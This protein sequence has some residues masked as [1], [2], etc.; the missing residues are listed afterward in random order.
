MNNKYRFVSKILFSVLALVLAVSLPA[1]SAATETLQRRFLRISYELKTPSGKIYASAANEG[2]LVSFDG[3]SLWY[4]RSSGLPEK[5]VYPFKASE[6]ETLTSISYD[7]SNENRLVCTTAFGLFVSENAGMNWKEI[8]LGGPIRRA[9]YITGAALSPFNNG[10]I[11]V[12]TSFSGLYETTDYGKTWKEVAEKS[13]IYRGAGFKE[14]IA[15]A[16]YSQAEEGVIYLAYSFGNGLYISSADRSRW[17]RIQGL[18]DE[19]S[20]RTIQG[21]RNRLEVIFTS[22]TAVYD[23]QSGRWSEFRGSSPAEPGPGRSARLDA[24]GDHR[25]M[26]I[27]PWHASGQRLLDHFDFMEKNGLDSFVIDIKDDFGYLTYDSKNE[28]ALLIGAVKPRIDLPSLIAEAD[29]RGFY[30]IGR[31]VVFKDQ[32]LYN[33]DSHKYAL[34]DKSDKPWRHLIA[35][36]N[37]DTGETEYEQREYWVDPFSEDVWRYNAGIAAELQELGVD[38]IQF[39]YI[40][41]PSDGDTSRIFFRNRREGMTR[42][43]ALESFFRLVR[44]EIHVPIST[45]LYGFNSYYRMGNWIGQ[46]IEMLA[47]YVDV[48]CPMYYPSHFPR[49]FMKNTPYIERAEDLYYEGTV[50]AAEI[51][52][53]RSL[54]RPYVQAFLLPSEYYMEEDD[55][56]EYLLRQLRGCADA[57]SSGYTLWN[58][59]NRYYMVPQPLQQKL[60]DFIRTGG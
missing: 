53:G 21:S 38:E 6:T 2:F 29:R 19:Y 46:N 23:P 60:D 26:Y 40:R 33:Y 37:S 20:I 52:S 43:N 57:G 50:R 45:D 56:Y 55:Y 13:I 47:D 39:D 17:T 22:G 32:R 51:T 1:F 30:V 42:I 7:P 25:G 18:S 59:S 36:E 5:A 24:A 44:E 34:W 10:S 8:S 11:L 58:M 4:R 35:S 14:E 27:G 31:I 16:V 15:A 54:I 28:T 48:I 9:N 3:G 12:S 49:N 41:F